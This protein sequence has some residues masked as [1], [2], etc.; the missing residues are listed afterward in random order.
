MDSAF[1]RLE[2]TEGLLHLVNA[3]DAWA[4]QQHAL[5]G[6]ELQKAAGNLERGAKHAHL[7]LNARALAAAANARTAAIRLQQSDA[8]AA[9]EFHQVTF[10]LD[11]QL[12][13][14]G[15]RIMRK[16]SATRPLQASS[17]Q[18]SNR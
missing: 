11:A 18:G 12:R 16:T 14:L 10:A 4:A 9:D 17:V 8:L 15:A 13:T 7:E 1:A 5:A 3:L 2:H 6:K